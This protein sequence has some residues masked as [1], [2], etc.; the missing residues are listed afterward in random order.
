MCLEE[1]GHITLECI[2]MGGTCQ[3]RG[4]RAVVVQLERMAKLMQGGFESDTA[5]ARAREGDDTYGNQG[6]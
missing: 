3:R 1:L 4:P 5:I 6:V 2:E